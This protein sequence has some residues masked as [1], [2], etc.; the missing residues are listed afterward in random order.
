MKQSKT[1]TNILFLLCGMVALWLVISHIAHFEYPDY[2]WR[3]NTDIKTYVGINVVSFWADFSF[4]TYI[5]MILFGIWCITLSIAKIFN[6]GKLN[7]FLSQDWLVCFIFINYLFTAVLYT[8]FQ[9]PNGDFGLYSTTKPLAWHN[10]GTNI[11]GHYILFICSVIIFIKLKSNEQISIKNKKTG[12]IT[13]S[14]FLITYYLVVKLL[15]EFAYQIR[16]FPYVIFDA[17]SFGSMLGI[18]NYAVSVIMLVVCCFALFVIYQLVFSLL[19]KYKQK[20]R[21]TQ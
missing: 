20:Q 12:H 15:G 4:F 18:Q 6:L 1:L 21:I 16:W 2:F 19:L 10:L 5:T 8:I 3:A 11:L 7:D 9:I 14:V 13:S 17:E